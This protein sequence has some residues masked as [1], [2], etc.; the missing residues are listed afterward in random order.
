MGPAGFGLSGFFMRTFHADFVCFLMDQLH[1][2]EGRLALLKIGGQ[3]GAELTK[4]VRER[5]IELV[6]QLRELCQRDDLQACA[7]AAGNASFY[8]KSNGVDV[9]SARVTLNRLKSDVLANLSQRSFLSI[10][11][12]RIGCVDNEKPFGDS[13]YHAFPPAQVDLK[14]AYNCLAAECSTAAVFHLMRAAEIGLR[15]LAFDRAV[16]IFPNKKTM[17]ELPLELAS[18]DQIIRELEDAELAIE[19]YPKTIARQKQFDFYHG[20]NMQFRAFKNVFRNNIMHSRD[21]YD[22]DEAMSL[23]HKVGEFMQILASQIR[24]GLQT[25]NIWV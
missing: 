20:A 23:T 24:E 17:V 13:V 3:G 19:N 11:D 16:K 7:D 22:R 10:A 1:G 25:P 6:G 21:S 4:E 9:S 8:L 15:A 14:E 5:L 18:W 2:E 12:D